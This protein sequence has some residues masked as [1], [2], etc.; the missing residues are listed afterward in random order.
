MNNKTKV[1]FVVAT[2]LFSPITFA[3]ETCDDSSEL[4]RKKMDKYSVPGVGDLMEACDLDGLFESF[5]FGGGAMFDFDLICGYKASDVESWYTTDAN[6]NANGNGFDN[7]FKI[8]GSHSSSSTF[9]VGLKR[10]EIDH[11][12]SGKGEMGSLFRLEN[13]DGSSATLFDME[14]G[15]ADKYLDKVDLF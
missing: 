13:S 11:I 14:E 10:E 12:F 1:L 8:F 5:N 7:G 4:H 3:S 15:S 6:G 9:G 2:L